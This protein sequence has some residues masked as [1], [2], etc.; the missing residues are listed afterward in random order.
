MDFIK[1]GKKPQGPNI[2]GNYTRIWWL[3]KDWAVMVPQRDQGNEHLISQ[4]IVLKPG[5]S[6]IPLYATKDTTTKEDT[7]SDSYD[8][9]ATTSTFKMKVPFDIFRKEFVTKYGTEDMLLLI[10]KCGQPYPELMGDS[11]SSVKMTWAKSEGAKA[12]E[13]NLVEFTFTREGAYPDAEYRGTVLNNNVF[14]ADAVTPSV[15]DGTTFFTSADNT[16]NRV[17]TG[18]TNAT[19]GMHYT[20]IGGGGAF[21]TT[22]ENAGAFSLSADWVGTVGSTITLYCRGINDFVELSRT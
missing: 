17:L 18:L 6:W 13:E 5:K 9:D 14:P 22:I 19:V 10:Q 12:S 16:A 7:G 1:L 3:Q 15:A 21:T 11:C 20:I 8:N 2:S 4:N